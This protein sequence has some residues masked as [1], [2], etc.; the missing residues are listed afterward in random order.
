MEEKIM[1][2]FASRSG[3]RVVVVTNKKHTFKLGD[4]VELI[5][6]NSDYV[7]VVQRPFTNKIR[8]YDVKNCEVDAIDL[9]SSIYF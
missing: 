6:Y 5:G 7:S 8:I 9:N 4:I 1:T 2:V 3:G